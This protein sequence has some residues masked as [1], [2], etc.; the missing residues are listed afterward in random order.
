MLLFR[1][2]YGKNGTILSAGFSEPSDALEDDLRLW[3]PP[4]ES[5][6]AN[7]EVETS[8]F[9]LTHVG[10]QFC[11]LVEMER[12]AQKLHI[13]TGKYIFLESNGK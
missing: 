11:D 8:K 12:E 9:L 4:V 3:L 13:T 5:P 10:D 2:R 6:P 1:L 7:I